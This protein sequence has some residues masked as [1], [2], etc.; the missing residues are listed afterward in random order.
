MSAHTLFSF[1]VYI[2]HA[3]LLTEW[4][5]LTW[6]I[7]LQLFQLIDF[8][9]RTYVCLPSYQSVHM[10]TSSTYVLTTAWLVGLGSIVS[11]CDVGARTRRRQPWWHNKPDITDRRRLDFNS[12]PICAVISTTDRMVIC[13]MVYFNQYI[14]RAE[15][16]CLLWTEIIELFAYI[17]QISA[18]R[19]SKP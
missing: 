16:P 17:I 11:K 6:P 14:S 12:S 10:C 4:A 18:V 19:T 15:F 8:Y 2:I 9:G 1:L 7:S 3:Q 13:H 5:L